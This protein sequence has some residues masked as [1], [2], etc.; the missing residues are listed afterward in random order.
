MI[1]VEEKIVK[2]E[3]PVFVLPNDGKPDYK[4]LKMRLVEFKETDFVDDSS[5]VNK[6][7]AEQ[8]VIDPVKIKEE[9]L[10]KL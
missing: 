7:I 8:K 10:P 6:I 3:K 2:L 5:E 1:Q 9:L 4:E